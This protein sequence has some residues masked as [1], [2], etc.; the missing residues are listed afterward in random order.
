[1]VSP[2][3]DPVSQ[4]TTLVAASVGWAIAV[5]AKPTIMASMRDHVVSPGSARFRLAPGCDF[6]N[7]DPFRLLLSFQT[8]A[9]RSRRHRP[10]RVGLACPHAATRRG[11]TLRFTT[12]L[13]RGGDTA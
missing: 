4:T 1:M 7:D 11:E 5:A 2:N 13:G 9:T 8:T 10:T 12:T 3:R 6:I